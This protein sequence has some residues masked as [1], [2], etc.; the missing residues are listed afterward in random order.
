M[1]FV[2][3]CCKDAIQ[4]ESC[5]CLRADLY[6]PISVCTYKYKSI[7]VC[8][9]KYVKWFILGLNFRGG[10]FCIEVH[11]VSRTRAVDGRDVL[12]E[13]VFL[14][15]ADRSK[16]AA[17]HVIWHIWVSHDTNIN[18]SC[19]KCSVTRVIESRDTYAWVVWQIW[20]HES[21]IWMR[22][23]THMDELGEMFFFCESWTGAMRRSVTSDDTSKWVMSHIQ[24]NFP[25]STESNCTYFLSTHH[26]R[27]HKHIKTLQ[28]TAYKHPNHIAEGTH[29][30]P[31]KPTPT[32]EH[33]LEGVRIHTQQPT[34]HTRIYKHFLKGICT[35]IRTHAHIILT[36]THAP[37]STFLRVFA[38][39]V[40]VALSRR[41]CLAGDIPVR[42]C[43]SECV[44]G[45]C[46]SLALCL[47]VRP[48][49][50]LQLGR[51][52]SCAFVYVYLCNVCVSLSFSI[53][54]F[55][56]AD[57]GAWSMIFL[58]VCACW[59]CV[60]LYLRVALSSVF[61]WV[62][63]VWVMFAWVVFVWNMFVW[64]SFA[65]V[66]FACVMFV[67]NTFVWNTFVCVIFGYVY[68]KMVVVPVCVLA[69]SESRE[70]GKERERGRESGRRERERERKWERGRE[71]E[72]CRRHSCVY[73]THVCMT[74][75][76]Q[77]KWLMR[78]RTRKRTDKRGEK[79]TL[80]TERERWNARERWD[81]SWQR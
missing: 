29:A 49:E 13:K 68:G 50:K 33:C 10:G 21:H 42:V 67:W 51:W 35:H 27:K 31:H 18:E 76:M 6:A 4:F 43:V 41:R 9:H 34:S 30:H 73:A 17:C 20:M 80:Q 5:N 28:T 48:Y 40:G 53:L 22:C 81:V 54:E 56:W 77:R 19:P 16:E 66:V 60:S 58:C 11:I 15:V 14:W 69:R 45:V 57:A 70:G 37:A 3:V 23:V 32:R 12:G 36:S 52:H 46:V 24:T 72:R 2:S 65:W 8:I 1:H 63:F 38:V 62:T 25:G 39:T 44:F 78:D 47:F 75:G 55:L 59:I 71:R 64:V 26:K 79:T 61:A 7:H 74:Q